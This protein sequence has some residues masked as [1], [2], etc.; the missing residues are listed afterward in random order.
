MT[1]G[2][3]VSARTF[4]I[5]LQ[6]AA[7]SWWGCNSVSQDASAH[8]STARSAPTDELLLASAKV[9]LPPPGV[10]PEYLPDPESEGAKLVQQY[11]TA[12]HELPTPKIHSGTDWPRVTRRMWLRIDGLQPGFAVPVPTSAQRLMILRYLIDNA[13][14]VSGTTLPPGPERTFFSAACSRCHELPDPRHHS[15]EEWVVITQR[16]M[17]RMETMLGASLTPEEYSRITLYLE[18]TSKGTP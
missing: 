10:V 3:A 13:L 1:R 4:L 7:V 6:F 12:C 17:D 11:C 8:T 15:Y 16:M 14:R 9:A 18:A 5:L 2:S